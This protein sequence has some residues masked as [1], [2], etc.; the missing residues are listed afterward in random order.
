MKKSMKLLLPLMLLASAGTLTSCS[1]SDD[2]DQQEQQTQNSL[3]GVWN[4]G[5]YTMTMYNN[6]TFLAV[7]NTN[8]KQ[9]AGVYTYSGDI[10]SLSGVTTRAFTLEAGKTYTFKVKREGNTI[11]LTNTETNETFTGTYVAEASQKSEYLSPEEEKAFIEAQARSLE[12][13]FDPGEWHDF[14]NVSKELRNVKDG[15]LCSFAEELMQSTL[16]NTSSSQR[17]YYSWAGTNYEDGMAVGTIWELYRYTVTNEYWDHCLVMSNAHGEYTAS[18]NGKWIQTKKDGDF[19]MKY[20]AQD[21]TQWVLTVQKSGTIGRINVN[22][23]EYDYN[24][25]SWVP[26]IGPNDKVVIKEG[27]PYTNTF[28]NDFI[29]IPANVTATLTR[30]GEERVK[31]VVNIEQFGNKNAENGELTLIGQSKGNASI[32][33]KPKNDAFTVNADFN[34]LNGSNSTCNATLKKGNTTLIAVNAA[35]TPTP[36]SATEI[37]NVTN[38]STTATILNALTVRFSTANGKTI[39]DAFNA[40]NDKDKASVE[41][42]KDIVNRS[43]AAYITNSPNADALQQATMK[44]GVKSWKDWEYYWDATNYVTHPYE[45]TRYGLTPTINFTDGTSYAFPDYFTEYFF[46]AVIDK[47]ESIAKDVENMLK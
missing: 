37:A 35:C 46:K 22:D 32:Y 9:Y 30:N 26:S 7:D 5:N 44:V 6:N 25:S 11:T 42:A 16:T 19:T 10:L 21:G 8:Q 47:A 27:T 1:S 40:C 17:E 2:G 3:V 41:A 43:M 28:D 13:Y 4:I 45:V 33:I 15:D 12:A 24:W 29:E 14:A 39:T 38:I 36:A 23:D 31:T 34:Y 18:Y 20:I